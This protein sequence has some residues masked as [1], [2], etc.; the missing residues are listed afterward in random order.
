LFLVAQYGAPL[1]PVHI[2]I[3]PSFALVASLGAHLW[4]REK[5]SLTLQFDAMNLTGRLIVLDF[6]DL[7]SGT[8]IRPSRSFGVRLRTAF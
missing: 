5:R 1:F 4:I 3:A 8:A 2:S 7:L 6:A